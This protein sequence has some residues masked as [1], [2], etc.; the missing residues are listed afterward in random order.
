MLADSVVMLTIIS[1][2]EALK[3]DKLLWLI[4]SASLQWG[5][6]LSCAGLEASN[7]S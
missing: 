2:R 4:A 3:E 1:Y 5:N 6:I 7:H